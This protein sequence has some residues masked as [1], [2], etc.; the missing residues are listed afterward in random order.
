MVTWR[1]ARPV[2][3]LEATARPM[4]G[5]SK[6]TS[7]NRGAV[8][9]TP[10]RVKA[11]SPSF[12]R[13]TPDIEA[14]DPGFD[15]N[16]RIVIARTEQ[17]IAQS[18]TTEGTGRAVRDAHAKGYGLIRGEVEIL[19]QLPAE[20]AQGI[21]AIP[22]THD[23]LI[24]FSNGSSTCWPERRR[25]CTSPRLRAIERLRRTGSAASR[26]PGSMVSWQSVSTR[27]IA[28]GNAR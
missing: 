1:R 19:D 13:Y 7:V 5:T 22:G 28:P 17:Y 18:V 6:A 10:M 23:A 24:R 26:A 8:D 27:P 14:V 20:Y 16:L 11:M 9:C 3:R 21:Y 2:D 12:V 4:A 15:E 25:R